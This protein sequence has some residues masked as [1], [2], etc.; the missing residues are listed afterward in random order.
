M[1]KVPSQSE[2]EAAL[3]RWP[4]R[5]LHVPT[6]TSYCW[7]PGNIYG[8]SKTPEYNTIT[9][10]WG[11]WKLRTPEKLPHVQAVHIKG[12]EWE[13]PRVDPQH[14]SR[15]DFLAAIQRAVQPVPTYAARERA[16]DE[17]RPREPEKIEFLWLDIACIDQRPTSP[18]MAAE[19]GRQADIFRGAH[20]AFVWLTT[21]SGSELVEILTNI[22]LPGG[23]VPD[24]R[25]PRPLAT[26]QDNL[27]RLCSD[28]WFSSLWT[29][30]EAFLRQ[31]ALFL[32]RE[33]L[34]AGDARRPAEDGLHFAFCF[35]ILIWICRDL[36]RFINADVWNPSTSTTVAAS[37]RHQALMGR[38]GVNGLQSRNPLAAFVASGQRTTSKEPDRVYGIQQ[39]FGFRLGATA[40]DA[41]RRVFTRQ[42]LE[43]QLAQEILARFPI[44]SQLFVALKPVEFGHGWKISTNSMIYSGVLDPEWSQAVS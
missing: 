12:V 9:Y 32:S 39:I 22:S 34:L 24:A 35:R 2:F 1:A 7:Q 21:F 33:G 40:A 4:R 28:P 8:T 20:H 19:V 43:V 16:N 38:I 42:E 14:F 23:L 5:L 30:Q 27:D 6:M 11:R 3:G 13:I 37:D 17:G 26:I 15:E 18:D 36:V 10:T 44:M 31:D 29:L 41:P 25:L